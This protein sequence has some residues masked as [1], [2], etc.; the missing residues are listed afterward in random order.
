MILKK[1]L[2]VLIC[3]SLLTTTAPALAGV[4]NNTN[5]VQPPEYTFSI[6]DSTNLQSKLMLVE[7]EVYGKYLSGSLLERLST[8]E[9][10][11]YGSV[12]NGSIEQRINKIYST[13]FTNVPKPSV[14]TQLNGIEWFLS[15]QV[16]NKPLVQ[17]LNNLDTE[18]YGKIQSG[19][20]SQRMNEL[21]LQ[22]YGSS[23]K[24]PLVDAE[25]P[26]DT[27][28]KIKFATPLNS[29]TAKV[30][31]KVQ[32]TAAEDI[33]TDGV[34]VIPAGAPGIG[35]VTKVKEAKNFGRNGEI[36][37]D[38]QQIQTFDGSNVPTILGDK[39]KQEIRQLAY[40]AGASLASMALL[41]PIGIVGGIFVHGKNIDLPIGTESYIQTKAPQEIY[42]IKTTLADNLVVNNSVDTP[43]EE[44]SEDSVDNNSS[45]Y[46]EVA[47]Y[48]DVSHSAPKTKTDKTKAK[49]I[50]N[51]IYNYEY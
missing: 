47:S 14:V 11:F 16:S 37:I 42:G 27:L 35:V 46:E 41:G 5:T 12:S 34:L 8:L 51:N 31:Q 22:A 19:T 36:S 45:S 4:V 6:P 25:I 33:V 7:E 1:S 18:I 44:I 24:S 2:S 15:R 40:A 17:R 30:G 10:E 20:L 13:L 3:S 49:K 48:D 38:F 43:A 21:A 29:K 28:I 26:A 50:N 9:K 23:T 39:A 32:F